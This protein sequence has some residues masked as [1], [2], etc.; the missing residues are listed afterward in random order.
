M[1]ASRQSSSLVVA[2]PTVYSTGSSSRLCGR[3]GYRSMAEQQHQQQSKKQSPTE[4]TPGSIGDSARAVTPSET[5]CLTVGTCPVCSS[6]PPSTSATT[7]TRPPTQS[8]SPPSP[9]AE[10]W[11]TTNDPSSYDSYYYLRTPIPTTTESNYNSDNNSPAAFV[12]HCG[13]FW[14]GICNRYLL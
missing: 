10:P 9:V 5:T 7:T 13:L 4:A 8:A 14:T 6:A 2:K 3:L 11:E 1:E 12:S